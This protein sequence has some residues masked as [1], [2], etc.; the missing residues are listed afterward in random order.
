MSIGQTTGRYRIVDRIAT[1]GMGEV[2][3]AVMGAMGGVDKPVALKVIRSRMARDPELAALFVEEAKVAM[4]LSHAN[5]VTAFDVG[6]ID[7]RLF[8]ALELVDG[9]DLADL[10]HACFERLG[11]PIPH[12]H[13]IFIAVEALKG[14][15]YAHRRKGQDGRSLHIVHRDV[16]PGNVLISF[17]GEVK[18]ADFGIAKSAMR[19]VSSVAG[20]VKGKVPYMAPEQLRGEVVDRRADLFALGAVLY[21]MLTG[22]RIV[23]LERGP[24]AIP[25]A[26]AGVHAR[27]RELVPSIPEE[28][29]RIVEKALALRPEDRYPN[30]AAMRQDLEQHALRQ[31][32]LLSSTDLAD[33]VTEVIGDKEA[34]SRARTATFDT[35]AVGAFAT[36]PRRA[37]ESDDAPGADD[38]AAFDAL[39]GMELEAVP[40]SESISVF[41]AARGKRFR[42]LRPDEPREPASA[43]TAERP[44]KAGGPAFTAA[45]TPAPRPATEDVALPE[46]NRGLVAVIVTVALLLIVGIAV[47]AG[48]AGGG[49]PAR[50]A[51]APASAGAVTEPAPEPEERGVEVGRGAIEPLPRGADTPSAVVESAEEETTSP[52]PRRERRTGT[53]ATPGTDMGTGTG[54]GTGTDMGTGV[55]AGAGTLLVNTDPW[56]NVY[57]DGDLLGPT[58]IVDF[59]VRSGTHRL[60]LRNEALGLDVT[61]TIVVRDGER[62]R[63]SRTLGR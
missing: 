42:T 48:L 57:L 7:D 56:C 9:I 31:G 1:G 49:E 35:T 11:Q 36:E 54:A 38:A 33:F 25:D 4:T 13:V 59:E 37:E 32:Y 5:V 60:T 21:E 39:L 52:R 8:L 3:R 30:A 45:P 62:K 19:E 47:G 50:T 51:R 58:P 22:E 43:G 44:A 46:R 23:E 41:T 26:L 15:D 61:E 27:P 10:I 40:S 20:T 53:G 18:V 24:G 2:Y 12:R 63:V 29:E 55:G 6:R 28:L 34:R 14:L 17:E 16:S